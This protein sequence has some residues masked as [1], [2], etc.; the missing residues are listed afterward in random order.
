MAKLVTENISKR[1]KNQDVLKHI[2][3]T[4]ENNEVYGLLG[5]NGACLLYTSPSPRDYAASRMPSSA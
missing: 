2:N 5:I 1:F 4:L 3:I